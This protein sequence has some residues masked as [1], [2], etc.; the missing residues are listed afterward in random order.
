M[1]FHILDENENIKLP[2][3]NFQCKKTESLKIM[4]VL[5][6]HNLQTIL[7]FGNTNR[8]AS[9]CHMN[10]DFPMRYFKLLYWSKPQTS[11]SPLEP[12]YFHTTVLV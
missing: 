8:G 10:I 1:N 7:F 11:Q 5:I 2:G 3:M 12:D 6:E 4:K 9:Y